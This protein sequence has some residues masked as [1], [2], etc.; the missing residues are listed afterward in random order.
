[1]QRLDL[2]DLTGPETR[3]YERMVA[4]GEIREVL[5]GRDADTWILLRADS[6]PDSRILSNDSFGDW[7]NIFP[8][9]EEEERIIRF[10]ARGR[11]I[12]IRW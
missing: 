5:G 8:L 6:H 12:E 2:Y 10:E 1:M 7:K 11:D 4:K 9:V 3:E